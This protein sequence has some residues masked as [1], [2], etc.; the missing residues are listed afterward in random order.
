M[1]TI[2]VPFA[3]NTIALQLVTVI[4]NKTFDLARYSGAAEIFCII[5]ARRHC[6]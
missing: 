5:A 3:F 2:T 1:V 6:L 4:L